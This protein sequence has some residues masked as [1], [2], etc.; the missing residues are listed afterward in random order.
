MSPDKGRGGGVWCRG[1]SRTCA[2]WGTR[3]S[4]ASG[5]PTIHPASTC[6]VGREPGRAGEGEGGEEG[7]GGEGVVG[8]GEG[9]E[10]FVPHLTG[11]LSLRPRHYIMT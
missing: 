4:G 2:P 1:D 5:A 10:T 11:G 9:E 8:D 6:T 3:R 7:R